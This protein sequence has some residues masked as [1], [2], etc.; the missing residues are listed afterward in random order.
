MIPSLIKLSAINKLNRAGQQ[1]RRVDIDTK[2]FWKIM[3]IAITLLIGYLVLWTI[4]DRSEVEK[5]YYSKDVNGIKMVIFHNGC[6]SRS[7][8]WQVMAYAFEALLL[9]ATTILTYQSSDVIEE[10]N[11]R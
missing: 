9:L 1:F 10:L 6:S 4:V 11:E 7:G 5:E 2:R 8:L 3:A